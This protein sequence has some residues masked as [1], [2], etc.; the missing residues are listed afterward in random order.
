[1]EIINNS[2]LSD[3]RCIKIIKDVINNIINQYAILFY[4]RILGRK[5][6]THLVTVMW[7]RTY[8]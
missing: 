6:T 3:K 7:C 2:L 8:A 1:M 5:E 4:N